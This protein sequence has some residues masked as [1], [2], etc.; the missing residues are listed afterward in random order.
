M[1]QSLCYRTEHDG[2]ASLEQEVLKRGGTDL[3][4]LG[5]SC[6]LIVSVQED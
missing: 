2:M 1:L 4:V 5:L 3:V 6:S